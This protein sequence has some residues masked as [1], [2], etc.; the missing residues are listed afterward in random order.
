MPEGAQVYW[1]CPL[2]EESETAWTCQRQETHAELSAALPGQMVGLL[3]GRMPAREGGG[4]VAV[5][6][7]TK[8]CW[9]PPR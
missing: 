8:R 5:Q 4:D 7:G 6:G 9:W 2:V 3:H 1:V